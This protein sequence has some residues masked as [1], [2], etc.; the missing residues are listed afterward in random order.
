MSEVT[1]SVGFKSLEDKL[2]EAIEATQHEWA[3]RFVFPVQDMNVKAMQKRFQLSFCQMLL[4]AAKVFV[5]Q[6]GTEGYDTN[7]AIMDLLAV[8]G[9][10]VITPLNVT[11]HD[12]LVILKEAVGLRI[13]PSP[14]VEHS[15]MDLLDKINGTSPPGGQGQEDRSSTTTDAAHLVVAAA[16]TLLTGQLTTDESAV[17]QAATHLELMRAIAKQARVVSNKAM[18]GQVTVQEAL[19]ADRRA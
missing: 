11:P 1:K 18:R 9:N 13:I 6:V 4:M 15:M 14:T 7:I 3:L 8:H 19:T 10:E 17:T 16:A 5:A 12:F 2:A